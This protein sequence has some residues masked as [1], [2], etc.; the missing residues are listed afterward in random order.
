MVAGLFL[1]V[2]IHAALLRRAGS[3]EGALVDVA[4]LD[5]Q[6]A[7]LENALTTHLV[8]G[9]VP[10]RLGTRHPNIA[11]FQAFEA[12]DG[13]LIV[14]CAGHDNQFAAF[15]AV[16]GRP[17]LPGDP[18]FATPDTRR[19]NADALVAEVSREL[20]RRPAEE[21]LGILDA[22]GVP[23]GP[24]NTV[25]DAVRTPQVAARNMILEIADPVIGPL[26]VAG[27]PIKLSGMPDPETHRPPPELDADRAA[28][29]AWLR[30]HTLRRP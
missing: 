16:L 12:G 7:I 22:A 1:A 24:V 15:C 9:E 4:M 21:W 29:L 8:T 26:F 25:A 13:R 19:L 27:N 6:L 3:G 23:C 30:E 14:V 28:I 20:R 11:P 10:R 17:E 5:C 2:G 18:R